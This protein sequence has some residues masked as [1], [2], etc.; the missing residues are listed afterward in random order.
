MKT[1][2]RKKR[3]KN[4]KIKMLFFFLLITSFMWLLTKFSNEFTSTI[5][6]N[7]EFSE[8]PSDKVISESSA[9][10]IAFDHT[11]SGFDFLT[12]RLKK[13]I[14]S[15]PLTNYS[16]DGTI[17]LSQ[18]DLTR[19]INSSLKTNVSVKNVSLESLNIKLD[20]IITKE[21]PIYPIIDLSFQKGF[22]AVREIEITPDRIEVS[23]ASTILNELN[24]LQTKSI[25]LEDL[26][27][28]TT[29]ELELDTS[30][31][32][33]LTVSENT[34]TYTVTIEEFTQKEILV[35]IEVENLPLET[36]LKLIPEEISVMFD[37]SLS[38][39]N[40]INK[41]EFRVVCDYEKRN[42]EQNFMIPQLISF[43]D[44]VQN[45]TLSSHK[46]KYLIFK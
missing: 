10:S 27:A 33:T 43:S 22:K 41:S 19:I 8:I 9:T 23:G 42:E 39:F 5:E 31:F 4:G 6:A 24:S 21:L 28:T 46:V 37:V 16:K 14:I 29:G 36:T 11:S 34:I 18:N 3:V 44:E 13:P 26:N 30:V 17:V 35:P 32:P 40:L 20:S 15:I 2:N 1:T 25:E 7:I 45:V 38:K 12:Y